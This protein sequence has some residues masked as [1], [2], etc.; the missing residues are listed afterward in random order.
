MC[1][2]Y[3]LLASSFYPAVE[4]DVAD[5]NYHRSSTPRQSQRR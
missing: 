2:D 3:Q 5:P 4:T 1:K